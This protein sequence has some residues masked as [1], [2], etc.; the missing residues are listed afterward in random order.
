MGFDDHH[1]DCGDRQPGGARLVRRQDVMDQKAST[2]PGLLIHHALSS[3]PRVARP[4]AARRSA[5]NPL[6]P[7]DLRPV[8]SICVICVP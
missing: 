3:H 2:T 6:D 5:T 7:R 4:L 8:S 1:W